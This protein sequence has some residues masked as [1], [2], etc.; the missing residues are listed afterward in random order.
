MLK[1]L[2]SFFFSPATYKIDNICIRGKTSNSINTKTFGLNHR[3]SNSEVYYGNT[4]NPLSWRAVWQYT[5][6]NF[7]KLYSYL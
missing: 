4:G 5:K 6:L 3:E 7:C 1:V 2:K